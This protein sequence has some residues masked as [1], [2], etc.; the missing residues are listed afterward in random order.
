M[1]FQPKPDHISFTAKEIWK[2]K[3]E[4]SRFLFCKPASAGSKKTLSSQ[5]RFA[6]TSSQAYIPA[7]N[8]IYEINESEGQSPSEPS[9]C[10]LC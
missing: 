8:K 2:R 7:G 3:T 1:G 6:Q 10:V 9:H 4:K 5:T